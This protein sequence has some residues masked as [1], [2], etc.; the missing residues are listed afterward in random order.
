MTSK[1]ATPDDVMEAFKDILPPMT[2]E[3]SM[4]VSFRE[5][6]PPT[7]NAETIASA[8]E[9]ITWAEAAKLRGVRVNL[10]CRSPDREA[11]IARLESDNRMLR[12]LLEARNKQ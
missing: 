2:T 7:I 3:A 1:I 4:C 10:I 6:G 11:Y 5:G 8:D 9:I 12:E